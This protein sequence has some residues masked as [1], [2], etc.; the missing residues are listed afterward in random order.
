M[1]RLGPLAQGLKSDPLFH[2]PPVPP[3][4]QAEMILPAAQKAVSLLALDISHNNVAPST[5]TALC[6]MLS[7]SKSLKASAAER[8]PPPA[9]RRP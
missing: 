3:D 9:H 1:R 2:S 8:S 5:G 6:S 7:H 4:F